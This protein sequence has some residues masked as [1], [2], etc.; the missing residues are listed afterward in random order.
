MAKGK[1]PKVQE[2]RRKSDGFRARLTAEEIAEGMNPEDWELFTDYVAGQLAPKRPLSPAQVEA[3]D[4]DSNGE[5]GGSL[6]VG[7]E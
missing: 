3:L 7:G 5:A 6:P 4:R 1:A 2:Y